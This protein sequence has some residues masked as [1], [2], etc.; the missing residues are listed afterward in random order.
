MHGSVDNIESLKTLE[1]CHWLL[2]FSCKGLTCLHIVDIVTGTHWLTLTWHIFIVVFFKCNF[3]GQTVVMMIFH[4]SLSSGLH[5]SKVFIL[6]CCCWE[7]LHFFALACLP[8]LYYQEFSHGKLIFH[9]STL[10]QHVFS[11]FI[12][13]NCPMEAK[14]SLIPNLLIWPKILFVFSVWLWLEI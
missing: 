11:V 14:S 2:L 12:T 7:M 3:E 9:S 13:K 4:S 5:K 6:F 1:H 8:L 10:S